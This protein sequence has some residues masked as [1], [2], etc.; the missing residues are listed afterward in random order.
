MHLDVENSI[1]LLTD[2]ALFDRF[3][4]NLFNCIDRGCKADVDRP[5]LV[6]ARAMLYLLVVD[7]GAHQRTSLILLCSR[8]VVVV[9]IDRHIQL[10]L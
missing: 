10:L 1:K 3:A 5:R 8:L 2:V 6:S 4:R 9:A 7:A